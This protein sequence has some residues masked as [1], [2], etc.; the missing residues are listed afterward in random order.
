ME[1]N[2]ESAAVDSRQGL[3]D[4]LHFLL[5]K[6]AKKLTPN[7]ARIL[8]PDEAYERFKDIRWGW[9]SGVPHCPW[10][11]HQRVY[12]HSDRATFKCAKC[13]KHFSVTTRTAFR[14]R[15]LE[16]RTILYAVSQRLNSD[17]SINAISADAGATYKSIHRLLRSFRFFG[18]IKPKV[19]DNRWPFANQDR[20]E[21]NTLVARVNAAL[22]YELPEQV[23][24]DVAQD[25]I[26][27]VLE[28]RISEDRLAADIKTFIRWH[29][30]NVEWRYDTLSLDAPV[31]GT[32]D[33]RW[34]EVIDDKWEH[35]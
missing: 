21:A 22:P 15:K 6:E 13:G 18:N 24:A 33:M 29:Y 9:H 19:K 10:C 11:G 4:Q 30:R 14:C 35:F 16:Y 26:L 7:D 1:K 23:R 27:G 31:P 12:E 5:S 8:K 25:V 3:S 2:G 34:D 20:I 32:E 28:G 17:R